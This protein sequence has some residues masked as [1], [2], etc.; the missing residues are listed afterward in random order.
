VEDDTLHVSHYSIIPEAAALLAP[1]S[2]LDWG[3]RP[4]ETFGNPETFLRAQYGPEWNR[5]DPG[6]RPTIS[7]RGRKNRRALSPSDAEV[8]AFGAGAFK[9]RRLG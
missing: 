8:E 3:G 7:K 6:Y 2:T 4:V 1:F 9:K 5:P